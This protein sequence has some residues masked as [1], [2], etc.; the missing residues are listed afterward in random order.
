MATVIETLAEYH[1]FLKYDRH[2]KSATLRKVDLSLRYFTE[3]YGVADTKALKASDMYILYERLK[4]KRS[5]KKKNGETKPFENVYLQ[6]IMRHIKAYIKWLSDKAMLNQ[7]VPW[8]VPRWKVKAKI[9]AYLSK[10]E[11]TTLLQ[12]LEKNL[13]HAL[14]IG[15]THK[16][17]SAYLWR[18]VIRMLYTSGLRNFELRGLTYDDISIHQL[19]WTVLWKGD[20]H[21]VFTFSDKAGVMLTQYL[22]YRESLFPDSQFRYIFSLYEK[23]TATPLTEHKLNIAVK[24]LGNKSGIKKNVHVHLFRHTLATHLIMYYNRNLVD[25]RDKLR[26]SNIAVTSIYLA[27]NSVTIKQMTSSLWSDL[28]AY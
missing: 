19:S 20:K 8:D 28:M 4:S 21:A 9:P 15:D 24:Q 2:L 27:S 11:M 26:H 23:G 6:K 10:E 16:I 13:A 12:Y 17:Y 1:T 18:A 5:K 14:L 25:V 22:Q 7:L 3:L